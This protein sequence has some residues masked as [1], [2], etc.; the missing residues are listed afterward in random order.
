MRFWW[1]KPHSSNSHWLNAW[2][3]TWVATGSS[4]KLTSM[5]EARVGKF[6]MEWMFIR[7]ISASRASGSKNSGIARIG[8]TISR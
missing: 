2:I 4:M 1:L 3:I 7:S 8:R 5:I 6:T